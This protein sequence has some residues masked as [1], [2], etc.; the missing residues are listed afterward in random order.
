MNCILCEISSGQAPASFVYED[1]YVFGI[2]SLD[3][4]NP[5]KV[6]VTPRAHIE[7]I[8]DLSE[9]QAARIFQAA[10]EIARAIREASGCEGLNVV[11]SNGRAGQ[12]DIFH[13]HLHLVPRFQ[14]DSILISWQNKRAERDELNRMAEEIRSKVEE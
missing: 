13:F 7:T 6:L 4:P 5:Y 1:E 10:V 2:M 8:Y 11:Q 12:Q 14:G 9:D 3:Q